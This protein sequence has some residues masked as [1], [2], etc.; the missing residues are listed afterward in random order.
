MDGN[1]RWAKKKGLPRLEGHR[2]GAKTVRMIAEECRK[3]RIR[4]VTLF[5]FSTENWERPADEVG[6]LMDLFT[7]YLVA[8]QETLSKNNIRLRAIGDL[9][10]LKD[11]VRDSLTKTSECTDGGAEMDLVLALSYGGREEILEAAR[12][13][14]R[15]CVE[16]KSSSE[17]LSEEAFRGYLYA[18]DIPDPDLL[19]RTSDEY[20]IS[21]FLL[22]QLAYSEIVIT[23]AL[24]PDFSRDDL[25]KCFQDYQRRTRRF[26]KTDEQLVP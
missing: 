13:F 4:Y 20:R 17:K 26:G 21:N 7:E 23:P 10:R 12:R 19:I 14:A 9:S 3:L 24:W 22:W 18:P 6:G 2:A 5:T 8:E 16:G 25:Y 1:G 11:S 15:D